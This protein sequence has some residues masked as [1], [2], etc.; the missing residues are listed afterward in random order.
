M[1]RWLAA[2]RARIT[3]W[4]QRLQLVALRRLIQRLSPLAA[5]RKT[6]GEQ[7]V[8]RLIILLLARLVPAL[9]RLLPADRRSALGKPADAAPVARVDRIARCHP[10]AA[11]HRHVGQREVVL[12]EPLVDPAGR[13]EFD[14]G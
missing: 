1:R 14:A 2:T 8:D 4:S 12:G 10:R 13:A 7:A 11:D 9:S 6:G 3:G 5:N